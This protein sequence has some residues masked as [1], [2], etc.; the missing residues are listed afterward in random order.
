MCRTILQ[1][2]GPFAGALLAAGMYQLLLFAHCKFR[3]RVLDLEAEL[4]GFLLCPTNQ[5]G[6][7]SRLNQRYPL[8]KLY[9]M[10]FMTC[11]TTRNVLTL[12]RWSP[13]DVVK[14]P[15]CVHHGMVGER[16][17]GDYT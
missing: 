13:F 11:R 5:S 10:A 14:A 3:S 6:N 12:R 16:K 2:V 9:D 8:H 15:I 7:C 17:G 4:K 1:W